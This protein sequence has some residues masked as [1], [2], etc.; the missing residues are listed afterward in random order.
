MDVKKPEE[1]VRISVRNLVEFILRTG[2]LDNRKSGFDKEA[3]VKGTRI[4][5]KIQKQ[6]GPE[7]RSEIVLCC[8]TGFDEFVLRVE[9]RADGI[10]ENHEE[11]WIDE[12]KG[13]YLDLEHLKEPIPIHKAQAMCYG[14]MYSLDKGLEEI[15]I[16]MTYCNLDTEEVK[17]FQEKMSFESLKR[18]YEELI[19]SYYKWANFQRKW[20]RERNASM[21][22]LEFPFPYRK[23][24][25]QIVAGVYHTLLNNRQLFVQAP[26]GI[27]KTMS[28]IF[29]A[30]RAM[31]EGYGEKLFYLT[32][33]TITRTVAAE[34]FVLLRKKGLKYKTVTITAK[35]KLC[36]LEEPDCNPESCPYAKGHF[37][38]INEAVYSMWT[39]ED[40]YTRERILDYAQRYRVCPFELCLDVAT[41]ADGI[42]CDYNYVFDPKVYLKRFFSENKGGE[43]YF[44][45]DEAH[46]L[47][48]RGRQMYSAQLYKE[49]ILEM[50][51]LAGAHNKKLR[52]CL[53]K[54]NRHLL[55]YKRECEDYQILPNTGSLTISL[56]ALAGELEKYLEEL[57]EQTQRKKLLE[58]YFQIRSFLDISELVDENYVIYSELEEDQRFKIKLFCVNPA[59]N[60]QKCL[61]KGKGAV[62]FSATLLPMTYYREMFSTREDDYAICAQSPF[63]QENRLL[64][65]G[66]DVSSRY[67]RRGE[68]EYE[69]IAGYIHL[70]CMAKPGNYMVFF[71]SYRL[72]RD[73]Y[74]VFEREYHSGE[75][76]CL[77]QSADMSEVQREEFLESFA[78]DI[79]IE[80]EKEKRSLVG[81]CIMGG[82]F[83]E[84]IDLTGE[85]LIG[86]AVIGTGLPQISN[87]R[88]I[89]KYYYDKKGM[90][91]FDYAYR[92]PGMNKVLQAAGRVIRTKKDRGIILLLDERFQDL[93]YKQLF[94]WEWYDIQT[95]SQQ[96]ICE[97]MQRFWNR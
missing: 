49:D 88:E 84:G 7:Y 51:R 8:E 10:I 42:I 18:W 32:A 25:R 57:K 44:L 78:K 1:T 14:Y 85:S 24:Q 4:H 68:R 35:E 69:K 17:R 34:A 61:D 97:F 96:K 31:G 28:S 41:W 38:R 76:T 87:E 65:I 45:I 47:V 46:N 37:D 73:V 3:M 89:L 91:G 20:K 36:I 2:D 93:K 23:G 30:I 13:V 62:F 70:M 81:F 94:P 82:I 80:S 11:V 48:E 58:Y 72:M 64:L 40:D 54:I 75:I 77:L 63:E 92:Y 83:S 9:G 59:L 19:L 60:L 95:G 6:M 5:K 16:Q 79:Q 15:G 12:I 74:E 39:A 55:E 71:P 66:R 29:P 56:T 52:R 21:E 90:N 27:G 43:Y 67:T 50:K 22:T 26:T 53:D 86:A 33:K